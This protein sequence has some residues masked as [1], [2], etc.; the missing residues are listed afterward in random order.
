MLSKLIRHEWKST[1]KMIAVMNLFI[2]IITLLGVVTVVS[3]IWNSESEHVV[4]FAVLS[5]VFYYISIIVV[6]IAACIYIAVKYYRNLYT[7]EG[8]LMHTLPVSKHELLLSKTIV[9]SIQYLIVSL[10]IILSFTF[11]GLSFFYNMTPTDQN[12]I[13]TALFVDL[14]P[15]LEKFMGDTIGFNLFLFVVYCLISCISSVLM[16]FCAISVGQLFTKHKVMGSIFCYIGLYILIQ[17]VAS[18]ITVPFTGI[19]ILENSF[20]PAM[21]TAMLAIEIL[22][23]SALTIVFYYVSHYVMSKKLN[24][25]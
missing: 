17:V 9:G 24:L 14:W 15:E 12:E 11:I 16:S 25:D 2:A 7:D 22:A 21:I 4:T 23:T 1:W 6:S 20:A 18:F 3:K 8:Y 19:S 13:L 10:V 5:A